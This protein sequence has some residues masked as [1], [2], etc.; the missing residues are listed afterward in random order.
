ME[1]LKLICKTGK[2]A[3]ITLSYEITKVFKVNK[4]V[5]LN[6]S[7]SDEKIVITKELNSCIF[8]DSISDLV[9]FSDKYVCTDCIERL[10]GAK[11]NTV[12]Y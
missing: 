11:L 3:S 10:K 6:L 5:S 8:C 12:Y 9:M 7:V 1:N 2:V 4:G